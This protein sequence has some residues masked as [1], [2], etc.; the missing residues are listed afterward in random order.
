MYCTRCGSPNDEGAEVCRNCTAPLV[1]RKTSSPPYREPRP[2]ESVPESSGYQPSLPPGY[3]PYTPQVPSSYSP[4]LPQSASGRSIASMVLSL[5]SVVTCGPLLSIPGMILGKSE[6]NAIAE[7][8]SPQAGE[9]YAKVGF[10]VGIGVT[11]LSCL[12]FIA[13]LVMMAVG[14]GFGAFTH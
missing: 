4:P 6:M 13:W 5:I 11:V 2:E 12:G 3:R 1:S 9:T 10:Y 8:R 7:G 14:A